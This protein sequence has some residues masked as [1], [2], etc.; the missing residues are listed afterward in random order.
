MPPSDDTY[1]PVEPLA[2]SSHVD[3]T[4]RADSLPSVRFLRV[5]AVSECEVVEE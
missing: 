1:P 2:A 4:P 5:V 3:V